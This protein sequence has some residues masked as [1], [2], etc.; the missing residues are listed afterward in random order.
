MKDDKAHSCSRI[1]MQTLAISM[2]TPPIELTKENLAAFFRT[3][4]NAFRAEE[5]KLSF[6]IAM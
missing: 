4:M 2:K 1:A 3:R 5:Q 6:E